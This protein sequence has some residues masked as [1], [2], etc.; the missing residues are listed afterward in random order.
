[1]AIASAPPTWAINTPMLYASGSVRALCRGD[2]SSSSSS[3]STP[4][5]KS[6]RWARGPTRMAAGKS[7][8]AERGESASDAVPTSPPPPS[9]R[10]LG[11][12][13]LS[14]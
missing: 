6:Q 9:I 8:V 11:L 14:D 4:T 3:S 2:S 7:R 10:T 5:S 1:M 12:E 13:S